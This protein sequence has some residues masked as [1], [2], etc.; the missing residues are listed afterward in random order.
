MSICFLCGDVDKA[1]NFVYQFII[2]FSELIICKTLLMGEGWSGSV[3]QLYRCMD[4][5]CTIVYKIGVYR[6]NSETNILYKIVY[7]PLYVTYARTPFIF[8]QY[9]TST[10]QTDFPN[11]IFPTLHFFNYLNI[12]LYFKAF[13]LK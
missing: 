6:S 5:L 7:A 10:L 13:L 11:L 9:C 8:L 12:P 3:I 2:N 1:I 4:F